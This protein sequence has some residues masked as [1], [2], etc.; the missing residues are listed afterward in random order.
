MTAAARAFA[1]SVFDR[2]RL[3]R[4]AEWLAVAVAVSLPWSTSATGILLAAWL[5]V[6]LPT[7]SLADVRRELANPAAG[8]PV[9]VWGI[10]VVGMLWSEASLAERFSAIR[11]FHKLLLIPLF[12]IQFRRSDRGFWVLGGFLASCTL[13]LAVSSSMHIW[14]ALGAPTPMPAVPVKDYIIQ[15]AEF[16]LCAFALGHLAIDAWRNDR[17]AA[18]LALAALALAFLANVAFVATGR[19]ALATFPVLLALLAAQRFGWRG[20]IAAAVAGGVLAATAWVSS[21][22]L[23][24]RV[25]GAVE[26]IQ[27]YRSEN[28]ETSVGY[29]LEFWKKSVEFIAAAPLVGHGTG[30]I[31][32]LFRH[33]SVGE[34]GIAAAVTANPHNQTL[35]MA[36]Q[37]GLVGVALLY[38]MWI[39]QIVSFRG[40]GLAAWLGM[41]VVAQSIVGS[42]FLAY[43][44][45][46]STGWIYAFGVGVLGGMAK[47]ANS[48]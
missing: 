26:E 5:L 16:L 29:R 11:G 6:F 30:A 2:A 10:V 38:A 32:P 48:E 27:Q 12:I 17:R 47:Q 34:A 42:L 1:E 3:S 13:L 22:Y 14:P 25:L 40:S 33:A 28:A 9:V 15:S 41:A 37:L 35:E 24:A 45:T 4:L 21:P 20:I 44:T 39:A 7:L 8:L 23:R 36:V 31:E 43:L 46:F 18:S 19:T